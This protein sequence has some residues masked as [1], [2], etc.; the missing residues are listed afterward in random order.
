MSS[1][2]SIS[3]KPSEKELKAFGRSLLIGFSIIGL[4]L[5]F[6]FELP[7]TAVGIF[8]L[9]VLAFFL[10]YFSPRLAMII[11]YPWMGISMVM[12]TIVSTLIVAFIYF[13]LLTPVGLL[14]KLIG[15]D[16]LSRKFDKDASTYWEEAS[17]SKSN[18]IEPY[19]EQF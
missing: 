13:V 5:Y 16:P 17:S 10:S 8:A 2:V 9:G 6:Y 7:N 14:F 1:L 12:G 3:W 18:D 4:V 15:R 11:Y 19:E